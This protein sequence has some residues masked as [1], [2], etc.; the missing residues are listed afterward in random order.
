MVPQRGFNIIHGAWGLQPL[1]ADELI[2]LYCNKSTPGFHRPIG[3][4]CVGVSGVLYSLD[5]NTDLCQV[6]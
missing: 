1:K 3:G 5:E 6:P 4:Q 2:Q